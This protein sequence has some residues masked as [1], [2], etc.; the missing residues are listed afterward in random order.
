VRGDDSALLSLLETGVSR[1]VF[2]GGQLLVADAGRVVLR[3][4][5]GWTARVPE[6]G[7][8]VTPETLYDVASLTKAVATTSVLVRLIEAGRLAWD[9]PVSAHLPFFQEGD[10]RNVRVRDLLSHASGLPAWRP[11]YERTQSRDEMVRLAAAESL[12]AAP[13]TRSVYSDLGFMLLGALCE[14]VGEDRLDRLA[15]RAVF[16]P[17]GMTATT[18]VELAAPGPRPAAAPTE[19]CPRRGLVAGEV[20]DDNCHAAGGILGHAGLFSTAD[21]LS[22]FAAAACASFHGQKPPGGFPRALIET[23]WSPAGVPGSTWRLGWDGPALSGPT[24]AGP[25]WPKDGVGH[26]G[27]TGCSIW[28]DPPRSRWAILLTN[29]VHPSRADERIKEL[30]PSLYGLVV[31]LLDGPP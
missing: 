21:D 14:Q 31:E 11:F 27:F 25:R 3:Q 5:F 10:K 26:L 23:L 6:P 29:R 2:P 1:Q 16:G 12:E 9:T 13:G 4:A 18:F 15:A 20:H 24:Q 19:L 22:R 8:P 28:I 7:P 17:L 30:R